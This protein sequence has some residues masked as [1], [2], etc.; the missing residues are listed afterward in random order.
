MKPSSDRLYLIDLLR[1]LAASGV[2]LYH[3]T[4]H[5]WALEGKSPV[6]YPELAGAAS[7]GCL[8]VPLFF[9][10]SG[11][12]ITRSMEGKRAGQ[13]AWG[14]FTRLF[15][16]YWLCLGT[17]FLVVHFWGA[18]AERADLSTF[19]AN[20]T[21]VPHLLHKEYV[22][23][24][25][26]TLQVEIRFYVLMF[27]LLLLRQGRAIVPFAAGWLVLS[28]VE[29][30]HPMHGLRVQLALGSAPFFAAGMIFSAI[31][32]RG[33]RWTDTP[34]LL[35][36]Y[37]L[38]VA[39]FVA[40]IQVELQDTGWAMSMPIVAS[41]LG[42]CFLTFMGIA[43]RKVYLT[44]PRAWITA[45]GGMTYPLYLLHNNIGMVLFNQ[46]AGWNRWLLLAVLL[47]GFSAVS[48]IVWKW[49]ERPV[50]RRL[51]A[52]KKRSLS[53]ALHPMA[54]ADSLRAPS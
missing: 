24:P 12:V 33:W 48:F 20:L 41:V 3:L 42:L 26:W 40:G 17:T 51:G 28:L 13:F 11:F 18:A 30:Y 32:A 15:P 35:G 23:S 54:E 52:W 38:G 45:C 46:C 44:Q 2:L 50:L 39:R 34:W 5:Q 7:Y 43:L 8:A 29:W 6:A 19:I 25:Y 10:I 36:A 4:F 37:T 21:M 22:D 16:T 9:L 1:F 47:G 31:Y 27:C 14:R 49:W 53:A